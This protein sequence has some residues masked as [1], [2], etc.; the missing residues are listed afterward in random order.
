M[1]EFMKHRW[2][3]VWLICIIGPHYKKLNVY[4]DYL[5]W[6]VGGKMNIE[7]KPRQLELETRPE[8]KKSVKFIYLL[9]KIE[10]RQ[11]EK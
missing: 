3:S 1:I 5:S 2:H 4:F 7:D 9:V 10:Q 6:G 11:L 8:Y